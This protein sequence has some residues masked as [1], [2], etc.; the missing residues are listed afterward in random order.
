MKYQTLLSALLLSMPALALNDPVAARKVDTPEKPLTIAEMLAKPR[1]ATVKTPVPADAGCY[2][3]SGVYRH[4]GGAFH[5]GFCFSYWSP[6]K[7]N[8]EEIV[9]HCAK[10]K[11]GNT[12]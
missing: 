11:V 1:R 2:I 3:G 4:K 6:D 9:D 5:T 8:Y 7:L 10:E 12:L